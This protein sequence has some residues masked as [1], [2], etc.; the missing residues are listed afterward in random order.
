MAEDSRAPVPGHKLGQDLD[1]VLGH[2]LVRAL[3]PSQVHAQ[4][5][6][7]VKRQKV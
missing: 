3:D 5:H 7:L 4:A 1:P 2:E 6:Q